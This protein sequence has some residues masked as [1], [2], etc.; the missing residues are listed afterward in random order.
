MTLITL[1]FAEPLSLGQGMVLVVFVIIGS[2]LFAGVLFYFLIRLV[3]GTL[4]RRAE[5]W[6]SLANALKLKVDSTHE[7]NGLYKPMIGER[8]GVH[9][10]LSYYSINHISSTEGGSSADDCVEVK[11]ALRRPLDFTFTLSKREQL[12]EKVSAYFDDRI[13]SEPFDKTFEIKSS[14]SQVLAQL[15][16][17]EM[18]SDQRS[19]LFAEL[20]H[21]SNEY[22]RVRFSESFVVLGKRSNFGQTDVIESMINKA[23][24]LVDRIDA[25]SKMVVTLSEQ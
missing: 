20:M 22:D 23:V 15:L 17:V 18:N 19:T 14:N 6:E 12:Y 3:R 16:N 9:I 10:K 24:Y 11:A 4:D 7:G 13:G 1:L 21:D 5:Q 25:A 8:S 2:L